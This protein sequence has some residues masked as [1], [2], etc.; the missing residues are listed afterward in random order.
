MGYKKIIP[1]ST[2]IYK[3]IAM[4]FQEFVS[5]YDDFSDKAKKEYWSK[6]ASQCWKHDHEGLGDTIDQ[7]VNEFNFLDIND[8][9]D[10]ISDITDIEMD[11]G[12]GT[13]GMLL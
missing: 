8:Y 5:R 1:Q 6:V 4:N 7:F 3:G 10:V 13:E 9:A 11:D 12:F 2:I